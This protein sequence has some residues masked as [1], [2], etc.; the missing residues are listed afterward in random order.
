[1]LQL[2][3]E[4]RIFQEIRVFFRPFLKG[5]LTLFSAFYKMWEGNG[6]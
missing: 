6:G 5:N 4:T 2:D 1:M 3:R